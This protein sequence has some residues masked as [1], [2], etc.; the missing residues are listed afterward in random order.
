M[1]R[2]GMIRQIPRRPNARPPGP[3][4]RFMKA[5]APR[6]V[7]C[8]RAYR[9]DR[10]LTAATLE[11]EGRSQS[12]TRSQPENNPSRP[13][14]ELSNRGTVRCKQTH[15]ILEPFVRMQA[16]IDVLTQAITC[17]VLAHRAPTVRPLVTG[18]QVLSFLWPNALA[19]ALRRPSDVA[20]M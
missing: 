4:M 15:Q 3:R 5:R 7:R 18:K 1:R 17:C 2:N 11:F 8:A 19:H 6:S 13:H 10:P 9:S 20:S 14:T 16:F 12:N